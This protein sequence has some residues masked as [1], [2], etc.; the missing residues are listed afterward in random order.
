MLEFKGTLFFQKWWKFYKVNVEQKQK[1]TSSLKV[2][3]RKLKAFKGFT[4]YKMEKLLS[5]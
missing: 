3:K 1:K 4:L 5:K 2:R